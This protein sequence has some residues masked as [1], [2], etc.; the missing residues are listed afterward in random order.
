MATNYVWPGPSNVYV[1]TATQGK[2][3]GALFV[4]YSRNINKF[5]VLQYC[6]PVPVQNTVGLWYQ[7]G[8]DERARVTDNNA[9]K[10]MWPDGLPR[11]KPQDNSENFAE[12]TYRCIRRSYES[13]LGKQMSEQA[14]WDERDRRSR[15]LA[16][17]AMTVRTNRVIQTAINASN[18]PAS[19]VLDLSGSPIS[20]VVGNWAASTSA[21][22]AIKRTLNYIK[23]L[24][25]LDTRAAVESSDLLIVMGPDTAAQIA[26]SQE[27]VELVKFNAGAIQFLKATDENYSKE[28][29]GLPKRLYNTEV[30]IEETVKVTSY[31]GAVSP[32][33]AFCMPFGTVLVLHRPNS[34]EGVEGGRSFSTLSIHI[35]RDDDMTVE[36]DDVRWDRLTN[37]A[38]TDNFDVNMTSPISGVMLQN[39]C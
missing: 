31:R 6:Q 37:V 32:T 10:F 7:M 24:I 13:T 18:W 11:P 14:A 34:L 21:R 23:Q 28:D 20:G 26:A 9:A 29:F 35:Y 1:P 17:Q 19:H 16:Q 30:I 27:I 8:L 25:L 4:D 5:K 12:L 2:N 33:A 39:V 3:G 38:V 22:L 36:T 15:Q